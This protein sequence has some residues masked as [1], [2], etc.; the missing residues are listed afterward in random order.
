MTLSKENDRLLIIFVKNPVPGKVKTRLANDIGNTK[1]AEVYK[2]L[3]F[4][5]KKVI[6]NIETDKEIWYAD[7]ISGDDLWSDTGAVKKFQPYGDLGF[8]MSQA[9]KSG[10]EN[11]YKK[12]VL[13]GSDC[14]QITPRHIT[15]AFK[16]LNS[17]EIV[18][19]PSRDGGYYLIGLKT[20]VPQLFQNKPWSKP[21]LYQKTLETIH[22]NDLDCCELE[23]LNDIDTLE[24][25]KK[26][27]L[28]TGIH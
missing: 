19:G 12:I 1:A 3:L 6:R 17:C 22:Q 16:N 9:F 13:I 25:L 5:T 4:H 24:D 27:R 14:L 20:Q 2:M 23:M 7:S 10:F 18:T 21:S 28:R 26:S 11:G 15:D 8:K